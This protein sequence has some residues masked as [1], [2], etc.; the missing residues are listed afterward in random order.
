MDTSPI[1]RFESVAEFVGRELAL[2]DWTLIDQTRIQQFADCTGDQQWIHVDVERA[3]RESPFGG[4]IAHGFLT[5][6]LLG[7]LV[8]EAGVV[9]PGVGQVINAGVNNVRFKT[10]VKAGQRVRARFVLKSAEAKGD[11]RRLLVLAST[12]EVEDAA[13][14]ALSAEL[15]IMIF[16]AQG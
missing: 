10:P 11:A 15:A 16:R 12:L 9:P 8:M 1:Y 14:P 2:S 3:R 5:L 4:T 6:S 13:E 7:T